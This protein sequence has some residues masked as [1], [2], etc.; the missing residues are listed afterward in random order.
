MI[1]CR[2]SDGLARLTQNVPMA[3]PRKQVTWR[4]ERVPSRF[5]PYPNKPK[6]SS[7]TRRALLFFWTGD[8]V[9]SVLQNASRKPVHCAHN[10]THTRQ[11]PVPGAAAGLWPGRLAPTL[12]SADAFPRFLHAANRIRYCGC[13][14]GTGCCDS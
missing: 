10:R 8:W 9:E 7:N 3:Q 1:S 2:Q 14:T 11:R 13:R 4:V 12:P 6:P 5:K